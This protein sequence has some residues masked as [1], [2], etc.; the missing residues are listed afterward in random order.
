MRDL[1]DDAA[2]DERDVDA[3]A[4]SVD[5]D[6]RRTR[7][8]LRRATC[9]RAGSGEGW[10]DPPTRARGPRA[11]VPPSVARSLARPRRCGR[12]RSP[13]TCSTPGLAREL[14]VARE[15]VDRAVH[16]DEALRAHELDHASLLGPMRVAADVD[17]AIGGA[18]AHLA[19]AADELPEQR[20]HLGLVAG[21]RARREDRRD[22]RDRVERGMLAA[23]ELARALRSPRPASRSRCA[24][25]FGR[26]SSRA[27]RIGPARGRRARADSRCC[28]RRVRGCRRRVRAGRS[29]G[30]CL[31]AMSPSRRRRWMFD[32]NIATTTAP[33]APS[34]SRLEHVAD[35]DLVPGRALG[36]RCSSSR[37]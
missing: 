6:G 18:R 17:A 21:D 33:V 3:R 26:G 28:A 31:R 35:V 4:V 2:R 8:P 19:A 27:A 9:A 20:V 5:D 1:V 30:S 13:H 12:S 22:R 7:S 23:R 34:T 15:V 11:S 29:C 14:G 16:R 10:R 25:I 36:R 24:R 32:A 37:S